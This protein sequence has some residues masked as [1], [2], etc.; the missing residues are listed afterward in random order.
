M[1][2]H[3]WTNYLY[4]TLT[5]LENKDMTYINRTDFVDDYG[6]MKTTVLEKM[7]SFENDG[8]DDTDIQINILKGKYVKSTRTL[9]EYFRLFQNMRDSIRWI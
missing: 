8:C 4:I 2:F 3:R 7:K 6:I 1:S 5:H 9:Y